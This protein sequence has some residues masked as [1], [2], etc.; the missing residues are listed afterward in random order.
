MGWWWRGEV[1]QLA[2]PQ[3]AARA[4]V[5]GFSARAPACLLGSKPLSGKGGWEWIQKEGSCLGVGVGCVGV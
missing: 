2:K 4:S 5:G 1:G 3:R